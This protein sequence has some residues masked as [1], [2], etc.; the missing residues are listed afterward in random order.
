MRAQAKYVRS[1][2]RKARLVIDHVR[3]KSVDE[4]R[5]LLRHTPAWGRA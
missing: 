4:A 5:A 3:G 2:A 1:S